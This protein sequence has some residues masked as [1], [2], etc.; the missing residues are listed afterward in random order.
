MAM[1][2]AFPLLLLAATFPLGLLILHGANPRFEVT[3][4]LAA[5]PS[6]PI[7]FFALISFVS[8]RQGRRGDLL[9]VLVPSFLTGLGLLVVGRLRPDLVHRQ[10]LWAL[11]SYGGALVAYL[12]LKDYR[13]LNRFRYLSILSGVVLLVLVALFG[14]EVNGARLWLTVASFQFQPGELVKLLVVIFLASYLAEYK[15]L[16]GLYPVGGGRRRFP[17]AMRLGSVRYLFPLLAMWSLCLLVLVLQKDLGMAL[18]MFSVFFGMLYITTWRVDLIC[19][20]AVSF[21][22][23]AVFCYRLYPHVAV[24]INTWLDPWKDPLGTGFQILQSLF[25][26]AHGGM[27]GTGLGKGAP[28]YI[29][30]VHTDFVF[31]AI[32]EELGFLGGAA[33]LLLCMFFA[34]R[35]FKA[36][37]RSR[38]DFGKFL[39]FGLGITFA[40]QCLIVLGGVLK[41]IPLTGITLPFVSFGG[42]SLVTNFLLL[43]I[44]ARI[45]ENA[46]IPSLSTSPGFESQWGGQVA[47]R[48]FAFLVL[49]G[50]LPVLLG[51]AY[52]QVLKGE[53][54][55]VHKLNPRSRENLLLRGKILDRNGN[56]LAES[57][58]TVDAPDGIRKYPGGEAFGPLIGYNHIRYGLAGVEASCNSFLLSA[59][60]HSWPEILKKTMRLPVQ[61]RSVILTVDRGL[62][63]KAYESL[64]GRRGA[65][66]VMN[67]KTG[68]ILAMASAPGF[69]PNRLDQT[70]D[71]L[72]KAE[73]SPL[74][75][76][77]V[78]GLY[79]PGSTFKVFTLASALDAHK[80]ALEDRFTCQG[81]YSLG[82]Y[83][84][85]DSGS[86]AHGS[87][88]LA[89]CL[90]NSCNIAFAQIGLRLEINTFYDYVRR[91]HLLEPLEDGISLLSAHFPRKR[92]MTDGTLAQ[93]AFGQGEVTV[94]PLHMACITSAIANNGILMRPFVLKGQVVN[95]KTEIE[96]PPG[97]WGRPI[98]SETA[99]QVRQMMERVI[100]SGTGWRAELPG[101]KVAGKTGTAENPHGPPHAWFVALAPSDSP[102][103]VVVVLIEQGG[104][105]GEVAAPIAREMLKEA[106]KIKL[107]D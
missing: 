81:S 70:W 2:F 32:S 76:R 107:Q 13:I 6:L 85:H 100:T 11:L 27:L 103:A 45:S 93:S 91:F 80:I 90:S 22:A 19:A 44:V 63:V 104:Y 42:S 25:S 68:E 30:A 64:R 17:L 94:S 38:D 59:Y 97:E 29:P 21:A 52:W 18:L 16:I 58:E 41:L 65:I 7:L 14:T 34:Q 5:F 55:S 106:L 96:P 35:C 74:I 47:M 71:S 78:Q 3:W 15:E 51:S 98:S 23:G 87:Q 69:D 101:V 56:I 61:G 48:R 62:Q 8:A 92:A 79:P 43:A 82:S 31:A 89:T 9:L 84:I 99:D 49:L 72:V 33:V 88:D 4:Q 20:G 12:L 105:G 83:V 77:V 95:E 37:L 102:R 57:I 24:R 67:P 39:A 60:G 46:G 86:I 36:A 50:F 26:I 75:N 28:D 73:S 1:N 53:E 54:L 40:A 10:L 66:V